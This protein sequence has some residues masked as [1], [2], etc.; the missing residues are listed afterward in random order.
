MFSIPNLQRGGQ[1]TGGE[2]RLHGGGG[3]GHGRESRR[4]RRPRLRMREQSQRRLR[5][6]AQQALGA[7][8]Q[9]QQ[10]EA[11]L[12]L[13]RPASATHDVAVG[14]HNFQP[15]DVMARDAVFQAAW[16]PGVG[17][18]VAAQ[19]AILQAGG[20]GRI[21]QPARPRLRLEFAGQHARLDHR[22]EI[23][24]VDFQNAVHA[25]HRQRDAPAHGHAS[26][27]VPVTRAA[28]RH[29]DLPL[30]REMHQPADILRRPREDDRL[31]RLAGEPLVAAV[32]GQVLN[33][34]DD[35]R[36]GGVEPLAEFLGERHGC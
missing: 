33:V 14:Q 17:G 28:R 1:P 15:Q 27:D 8:E 5:A 11:R 36:L 13:V 24:L 12:V 10:I 29:G 31:R 18:D 9:A 22:H 6:D 2:N 32:R 26:A 25:R 19:T 35:V 16:P 7:D 20:V 34:L 3:G 23:A 30:A 4:E 21:E